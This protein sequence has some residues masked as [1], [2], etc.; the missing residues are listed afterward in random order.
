MRHS[1]FLLPLIGVAL[2]AGCSSRQSSETNTPA[3]ATQTAPAAAAGDYKVALLT[4]GPVTD[5]GWNQSAYEGLQQIAKDL[6]AKTANQEN[7]QPNQFEEAFRDYANQG[8]SIVIGHG[9]EFN[10]AAMKVAKDYPKTFFVTTGGAHSAAN[11]IPVIFSAEEGCY[12]Q[13]MEAGM[14][15][16]T[17][18]GGFVGGQQL[19]NVK[20]A[21]DA[22]G[23]GAKAVNPKFV[24]QQ[25]YIG[26]WSDVAA[27]KGQTVALLSNGCDV[28]SQ[29]CD[30]A[31][32]GVFDAAGSKPNTYTFG[33][34]SDQ[35]SMAPNVFSSFILDVP[36][37]LDDVAKQIKAGT[38][39]GAPLVLG[40][41]SGDIRLLDNPKFASVLT[42][43]QKA[44]L[45]KTT[46]DIEDGKVKVKS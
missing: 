26:N 33:A 34:N 23:L 39:Q 41:K 11:V 4:T 10:D 13:G 9:D 15:S 14:L 37:A 27:A 46:Q 45:A 30:A 38:A 18:K 6:G 44:T 16:K 24:F 5:K 43:D 28:I 22:F 40:L 7:L 36:K 19:P 21:A 42:A 35:N 3:P 12:L 17:G 1:L 31:A 32:K 8:Y 29:N 25:T 20:S 2:V